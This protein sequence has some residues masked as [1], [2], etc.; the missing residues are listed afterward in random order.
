MLAANHRQGHIIRATLEGVAFSL[1]KPF[2]LFAEMKVPAADIRVG[3]GGARF[4]LWRQ[5]Q[6]DVYG[7]SVRIR[8]RSDK[9]RTFLEDSCRTKNTICSRSMR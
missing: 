4:P 9:P 1:R 7:H 2:S 3:G 5:I 8:P 6:A